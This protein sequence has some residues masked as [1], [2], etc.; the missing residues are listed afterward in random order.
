MNDHSLQGGG[1]FFGIFFNISR[2]AAQWGNL[3]DTAFHNLLGI[4]LV[5]VILRLFLP[6]HRIMT[7]ELANRNEIVDLAEADGCT[8]F[9][10]FVRALVHFYGHQNLKKAEQ[11]FAVYLCNWPDNYVLPYYVRLYLEM[12]ERDGSDSGRR[13]DEVTGSKLQDRPTE[14][15]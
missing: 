11:D 5:V 2:C 3:S 7:E 8:E 14:T 4:L 6:L 13:Q 12:R 10:V 9:D 15:G 1:M